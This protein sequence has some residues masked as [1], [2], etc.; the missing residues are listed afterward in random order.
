MADRNETESF[1]SVL[2]ANAVMKRELE[3]SLRGVAQDRRAEAVAAF[4]SKRGYQVDSGML[5][6]TDRTIAGLEYQARDMG[7][8][9]R[10]G[11]IL[12]PAVPED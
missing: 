5:A 1:L 6:R 3:A 12:D 7:G 8:V 4:A 10:R 9:H 11:I 2:A